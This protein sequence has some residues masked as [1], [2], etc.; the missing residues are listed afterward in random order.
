MHHTHIL[1]LTS[2]QIS[3][4]QLTTNLTALPSHHRFSLSFR[5]SLHSWRGSLHKSYLENLENLWLEFLK[6]QL[7]LCCLWWLHLWSSYAFVIDLYCQVSLN[8]LVIAFRLIL[9]EVKEECSC[10]SE[11]VNIKILYISWIP[12]LNNRL[13][14]TLNLAHDMLHTNSLIFCWLLPKPK[15]QPKYIWDIF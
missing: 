5:G 6:I 4:S 13:R 8:W 7:E 1:L 3:P 14:L 9:S 10:T 11:A 2:H 15:L 12:P